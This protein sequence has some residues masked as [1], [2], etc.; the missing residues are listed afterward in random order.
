MRDLA[1]GKA[2]MMLAEAAF[3]CGMVGDVHK[4]L[5]T[6]RAARG[7]AVAH[8]GLHEN[9]VTALVLA[10]ALQLSGERQAARELLERYLPALRE[11][12]A[13]QG[14]ALHRCTRPPARRSACSS[15]VSDDRTPRSRP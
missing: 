12:Q 7:A 15:S 2:A 10:G 3:A 9:T 5:E 1:P 8:G 6:A 11:P 13:L 4:A 14:R